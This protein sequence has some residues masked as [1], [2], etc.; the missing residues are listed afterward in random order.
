MRLVTFLGTNKYLE[1]RY[2][3]PD[4]NGIETCYV[5]AAIARLWGATGV[6][7]LAT[8]EAQATHG[9][10][11]RKAL[12]GSPCPQFRRI[13]AGRK[14][15][16]FWEQFEILRQALEADGPLILDITHG[17]RS[18]P[19]FAAG[20]LAYLRMAGALEDREVRVLYGRFLP[21]EPDISPIWDL[22][23]FIDLLDWAQGAALMVRT[24]QAQALIEVA[25]RSDRELRSRLAATGYRVFPRTDRL[26]RALEAFSDDLATVRIA[27]L[28]TGYAQDD[29]AK[30][31]A[32][33]SAARLL[34]A[35]DAYLDVS[36]AALPVL[37][38][39]L[40]RVRLA[41]EGLATRTLTGA[42]GQRALATLA[43][44]YLHYGRYPEAA[45]T[46]REALV[47]ASTLDPRAT[48]VKSG[49]FDLKIRE[50][51]E[52]AWTSGDPVA[53]TISDVRNDIEH[54]GFRKQP[55]A[56]EVLKRE[57]QNLVDRHLDRPVGQGPDTGPD[58]T[59]P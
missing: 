57:L 53:R 6:V 54:G 4:G 12:D 22:T 13:P 21:E 18:Q 40:A 15:S 19:F 27:A 43:R 49:S 38:P 10:G 25:R 23:P 46:L 56:A 48:E 34:T 17:F 36:V 33:G 47:S 41:A 16:E 52:R 5:A 31:G 14:E 45:I 8:Q 28:T 44:R 1:T 26:V 35:L 32:E 42:D 29:L 3:H 9:A 7:V 2:V 30:Q 37:L 51:V 11:L 55:K 24:G 39:V 20:A 50:E 59:S 58:S